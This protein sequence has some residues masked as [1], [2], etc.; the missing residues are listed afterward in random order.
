MQVLIGRLTENANVKTLTDDRQV[1]NF[2][3]A[4]NHSFTPKG[5]EKQK[6]TTY[7]QCSYWLGTGIAQ[8]LTKGTLVEVA[9]FISVDAYNNLQGEAKGVLK[10]HCN[11]IQ[12]HGGGSKAN[13]APGEID[14]G[15]QS[16]TPAGNSGK[17]KGK[18]KKVTNASEVTEPI[19]D[20]PF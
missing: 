16:E 6:R 5:G 3:I 15:N 14:T 13:G 9:G 11:A 1:V 4:M 18:K 17:G 8:Y 10:F 19:D 12:L 2:S 20:L 7:A